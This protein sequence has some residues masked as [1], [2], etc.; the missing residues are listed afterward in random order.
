MAPV[1]LPSAVLFA[2]TSN[3]IR[4]PMAEALMKRLHGRAVYVQSAGVRAGELDPF[5]IAVMD[6]IG[7]DLR[8]HRS[9]RFDELDDDSFDL[10]VSLSPEA[11]HH[12]VEMTR[13]MACDVEFWNIFDPTIIEGSRG[14]CLAAYRQ[15]R[16]DLQQ[17]ILKRFPAVTTAVQI[18]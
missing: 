12:A 9:R 15:V 2:C 16:D 18:E 13:I 3:A 7:I 14:A 17:R 8:R 10:I 1:P 6:E 4:S 5:T 11:Q